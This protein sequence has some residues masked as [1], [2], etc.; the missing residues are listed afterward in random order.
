MESTV[1]GV[2]AKT[3]TCFLGLGN[4][5]WLELHMPS[6]GCFICR[7][8]SHFIHYVSC[9]M[10][11]ILHYIAIIYAAI[12]ITDEMWV[13]HQHLRYCLSLQVASKPSFTQSIVSVIYH[14]SLWEYEDNSPIYTHIILLVIPA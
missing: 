2:L 12:S 14:L 9:Y 6:F 13:S 5:A 4:F 10:N 1:A 3:F 11:S 7:S 8:N